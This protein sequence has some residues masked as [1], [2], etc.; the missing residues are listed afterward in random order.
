MKNHHTIYIYKYKI[1]T[2]E[3]IP[4]VNLST[5]SNNESFFFF[6]VAQTNNDSIVIR[7]QVPPLPNTFPQTTSD[8]HP[9]P[10]TKNKEI[11]LAH[12]LH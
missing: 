12:R 5:V 2:P 1:T 9:L 11:M 6:F 8:F 4:K 7:N 3:V 10:P